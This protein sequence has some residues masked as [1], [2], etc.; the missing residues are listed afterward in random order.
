MIVTIS[1]GSHELHGMLSGRCAVFRFTCISWDGMSVSKYAV[2]F[3][4]QHS[5]GK[6]EEDE[7]KN[8][9]AILEATDSHA[10]YNIMLPAIRC[11]IFSVSLHYAL[12]FTETLALCK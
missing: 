10:G 12:V 4:E 3:S 1:P 9:F 8:T 11:N 7:N 6:N 2:G 5:I